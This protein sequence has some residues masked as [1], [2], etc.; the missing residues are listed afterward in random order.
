MPKAAETFRPKIN[1][2]I[3]PD[4]FLPIYQPLLESSCDI[5]F[6]YGSRDS[7]KSRDVAQ[8][9]LIECMGNEKF[10]C[11]MIRK[12]G[13]TVQGSQYDLIKSVAEDWKIDHL[14]KFTTSPQPKIVCANGG[15]FLGRGMDDPKKIKSLAE[16]T[17]AWVE[18]GS[19]LEEED[20]TI[21]TTSLRSNY[22]RTKI[23][24]SFNPDIPGGIPYEEFWLFKRYFCDQ[25]GMEI[26]ELTFTRTITEFLEDGSKAEIRY[27]CTHSTFYDNRFCP[28]ERK[29]YYE[30]LARVSEYSH[31]VY[32]LGLW[33]RR[34]TGGEFLKSFD[35]KTHASKVLL[36]NPHTTVHISIDSNVYPHIAITCWQLEKRDEKDK[37]VWDVNQ[38]HE[39]PASDPE[40]TAS[41]A[42]RKII[43]WLRSIE[44]KSTIYWYGDRS[45]KAR[46][47]IDD[48]KRSFFQII[49]ETL[50]NAGFRT[51][52]M[53][54][55]YAPPVRSIGEFVNAILM[56]ELT[57]ANI[58]ISKTCKQSINDY[59][60]TK[61]D[62]DGSI[63]KIRKSDYEGGPSYEH[64]G[65]LTDTLKDFI[66]QAF[67]Q[68]YASY[69]NK[70]NRLQV[71]GLSRVD[72]G[73]KITL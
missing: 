55:P 39:L 31:R 44:Y 42:A 52:D 54:H 8:M 64:N 58:H 20:W 65:H 53:I 68:E 43:N 5:E 33:A 9:L 32:C 57:F 40:N 47:N 62:K 41:A 66:Y 38:I 2:T 29:V 10:K 63:L 59:I 17:H 60:D 7:G 15:V 71:G 61:T 51:K 37:M 4:M 12:V 13:N 23:W 22:T 73:P 46:N 36:Y 30:G 19:D 11:A 35:V 56:G 27:R 70:H 34:K 14:F 45:T 67:P 3:D 24:Y 49:D 21:I 28:A 48:A 69:V 72:R 25:N 18:E 16:P 1:V 50:I 26:K 6:L